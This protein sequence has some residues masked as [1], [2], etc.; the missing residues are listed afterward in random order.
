MVSSDNEI[1]SMVE[2]K[3]ISN[4]RDHIGQPL[5]ESTLQNYDFRAAPIVRI[6]L[7]NLSN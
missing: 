5:N 3:M 6:K 2:Y 4:F 1:L 7:R